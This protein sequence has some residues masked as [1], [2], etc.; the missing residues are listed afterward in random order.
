LDYKQAR[1]RRVKQLEQQRQ[2][3]LN[4]ANLVPYLARL[5]ET[6]MPFG[7]DRA[8]EVGWAQV[9]N[10]ELFPPPLNLD[11]L[12]QEQSQALRTWFVAH[13]NM[14]PRKSRKRRSA[15]KKDNDFMQLN[16]LE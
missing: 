11:E 15:P 4:Q 3:F 16:L 14:Q 9:K 7:A 12:D 13:V 10:L 8:S 6:L 1:Q 2:V 5:P